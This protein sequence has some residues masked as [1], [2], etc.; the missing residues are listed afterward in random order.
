MINKKFYLIFFVSFLSLG[1]FAT[2]LLD[3]EKNTYPRFKDNPFLDD[4]MRILMAPYLLPLDHPLMPKLEAIFSLG[5]IVETKE[6]LLAAGFSIIASKEGSFV[7]IVKHADLPGYVLKLYLDSET[8]CKKEIPNWEW[9]THRCLGA[10]ILKKFIKKNKILH[11]T[12]PDKWLYLLPSIP[13]TGPNPQP[14]IVVETDMKPESQEATALAWKTYVTKEHLDELFSI[15]KQ[16]YGTVGLVRNVH[17]TKSGTFAFTDTQYPI[18]RLNLKHVG[19]YL[20]EEMESYWN[21]LIEKKS[22]YGRRVIP[23]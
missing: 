5:R 10:D 19:P 23:K 15:L 21:T 14:V 11:F 22:H 20:S 16:G 12:V 6:T 9:L 4:R 17:Y 1:Y 18:R 8:R 3:H 7:T 13:S 2:A